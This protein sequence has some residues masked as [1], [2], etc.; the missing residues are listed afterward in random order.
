MSNAILGR[1]AS[2]IG[3]T[4]AVAKLRVDRTSL[5]FLNGFD[6]P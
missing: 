4:F 1:G 5:V 3:P 2:A 6:T